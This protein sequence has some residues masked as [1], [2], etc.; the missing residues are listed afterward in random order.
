MNFFW[1]IGLSKKNTVEN[2]KWL[3]FFASEISVETWKGVVFT[4]T[5]WVKNFAEIAL[6]CTVFEI[7][8]FLCFA[9]FAKNSKIQWPPFLA[10]EIFI[11]TWKG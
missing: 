3:P 5:L 6:S 4:D 7:Q 9:I 10:S 11:E 8:P 1:K 2:S